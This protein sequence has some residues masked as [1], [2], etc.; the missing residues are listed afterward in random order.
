MAQIAVTFGFTKPASTYAKLS[1]D[2]KVKLNMLAMRAD[3]A[4]D[5]TKI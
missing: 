2:A 3:V 5:E 4:Y 1:E